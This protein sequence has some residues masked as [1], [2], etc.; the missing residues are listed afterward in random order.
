M[1]YATLLF[2]GLFAI[3]TQARSSALLQKSFALAL[4][5]QNDNTPVRLQTV[6]LPTMYGR[7]TSGGQLS[8]DPD[9]APEEVSSVT[10]DIEA[11]T[12]SIAQ[13]PGLQEPGKALQ[14][15]VNLDNLG[16][17]SSVLGTVLDSIPSV[18][19]SALLPEINSTVSPSTVSPQR[20]GDASASGNASGSSDG[21]QGSVDASANAD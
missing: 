19:V 11:E 12:P 21:T 10:P 6:T 5:G 13:Q 14:T 16:I 4:D 7:L 9:S 1:M 20:S 15:S 17:D 3:L 8:Q 18:D 2:I